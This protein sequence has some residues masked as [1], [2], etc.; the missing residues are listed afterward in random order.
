MDFFLETIMV[1]FFMT[2]ALVFILSTLGYKNIAPV[3]NIFD[4]DRLRK[5]LK[6]QCLKPIFMNEDKNK[7]F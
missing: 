1:L 4:Y 6:L 5:F 7:Y 3:K 2:E